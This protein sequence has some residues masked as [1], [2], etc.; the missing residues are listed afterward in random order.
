M[1]EK[2]HY[3]R[4]RFIEEVEITHANQIY[5]G[6]VTDISIKGILIKL[7]EM[8][9]GDTTEQNWCIRLPLSENVQIIVNARPSHCDLKSR[10]VGFEFTKIDADSMAHLRRLL[11]LNTG[12]AAAIERE[13]GQMVEDMKLNYMG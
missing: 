12:D 8:P 2:R 7:E 3:K 5:P 11:E 10:A 4:V 1:E 9:A 13:L 6:V